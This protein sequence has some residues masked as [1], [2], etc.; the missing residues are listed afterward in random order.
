[1]SASNDLGSLL[2]LLRKRARM[3]QREL[4]RASGVSYTQISDLERATG[5][6]PSPTTLRSIARGLATDAVDVSDVDQAK[7]DAFYTQLMQAA[8]YLRGLGAPESNKTDEEDVI[9]YLTYH[10]GDAGV[11]EQLVRLAR[12]YPELTSEEQMVAG[13]L[14]AQWARGPR[15]D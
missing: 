4:S 9:A 15:A 12:R 6:K 2:A 1:M 11:A 7:A 5:G 13:H 3:S 14:I 10:S 8:G